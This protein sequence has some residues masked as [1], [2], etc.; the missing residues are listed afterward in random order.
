MRESQ[1]KG[2]KKRK[3]KKSAGFR[4][5]EIVLIVV[6][7]GAIGSVMFYPQLYRS[8]DLK[9]AE[10][11]EEVVTLDEVQVTGRQ[12]SQL[13][14]TFRI[15]EEVHTRQVQRKVFGD[16]ELGDRISVKYRVGTQSGKTYLQ[17]VSPVEEEKSETGDGGTGPSE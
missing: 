5:W 14:L 11:K 1:L 3:T 13:I 10:L 4:W 9:N 17:T 15:G 7:L 2:K 16:L 12:G 6:V 8:R